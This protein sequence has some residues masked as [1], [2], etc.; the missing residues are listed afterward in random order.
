MH[1]LDR[2]VVLSIVLH[3]R[4][5]D[6]ISSC[7]PTIAYPFPLSIAFVIYLGCFLFHFFSYTRTFYKQLSSSTG[8]QFLK[9]LSNELFKLASKVKEILPSHS[10][11]DKRGYQKDKK[12]TVSM[13]RRT[14]TTKDAL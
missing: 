11:H 4:N 6:F 12:G 10:E 13:K 1:S 2:F 5:L 7:L 8:R 9:L 3:S 14:F